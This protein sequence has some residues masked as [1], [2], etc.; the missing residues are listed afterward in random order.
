M[1]NNHTLAIFHYAF[2]S[3]P[4]RLPNNT[5]VLA[6]F[7]DEQQANEPTFRRALQ[8]ESLRRALPD[9]RDR[10]Q[11]ERALEGRVIERRRRSL[12]RLFLRPRLTS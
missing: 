9:A 6:H 11:L 4:A 10:E 7:Q 8:H 3:G 12:Q 5:F 2:F 1:I